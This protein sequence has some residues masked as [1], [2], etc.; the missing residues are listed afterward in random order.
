MINKYSFLAVMVAILSLLT[1]C[2]GD[3]NVNVVYYDDVA[4]TSF[5]LGDMKRAVHTTTSAGKD[6]VY[7]A[8]VTGANFKFSIDHLN[9]L[10]YNVDSLPAGTN[11][12]NNVPTINTY[13]S[14]IAFLKSLKSDS[15]TVI[16]STDSIDFSK[17]RVITV[18]AN[19]G[20]HTKEYK[21]NVRI[22][23]EE[24]DKMYWTKKTSSNVIGA[25]E[26]INSFCLG[27]KVY[28]YGVNGGVKMYSSQ[29]SNGVEWD[30]M[31]VPFP[32]LPSVVVNDDKAYALADAKFYT[33]DSNGKWTATA[34]ATGVK[35]LVS[36]TANAIYALSDDG[37]IVVTTNSGRTWEYD[38]IDS[39]PAYLPQSN[40]NCV[41]IPS[42]TNA[43]VERI[44]LM[45]IR[46][47]DTDKTPVVWSKAVDNAMPQNSLPWMYQ[48][49]DDSTWHHAPLY[50]RM[51]VVKYG[52]AM[53]MLGA[54][55]AEGDQSV[56]RFRLYYSLD[57]GL[58]WLENNKLS[59]PEE[60]R[61]STTSYSMMADDD[62]HI[63]LFCGITGDV[64]RC[65]YS[66]WSWK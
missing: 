22:H 30:E 20:Q 21:V 25:L 44:I 24:A 39:D 49:F 40:I 59:L 6:S 29:V 12:T 37:K 32:T 27:G 41:H 34:D 50:D 51:S 15:V 9:G 36:A 43:D 45:G 2:L 8:T 19:D 10:I 47:N 33:L 16:S 28:V 14:G 64:W 48:P 5:T 60:L 4:I 35:T 62:S 61:S 53:I 54:N 18:L 1:S 31:D 7:Y 3:S 26:D 13:N 63:W 11:V 66:T 56:V 58:N 57:G 46:D 23:T 38:A 17:D 65:H 42:R 52:E 55:K